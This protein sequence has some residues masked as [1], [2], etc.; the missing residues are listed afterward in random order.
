MKTLVVNQEKCTACRRCELTCSFHKTGEFN[1]ASSRVTVAIF[2][3]VDFYMPITCQQ[4]EDALCQ[5]ACPAAA[6]SRSETTGAVVI[7]ENRCIGCQMCVMVCPFGAVAFSAAE[8]KV[9]KCDLCGGDPECAKFCAWG[10]IEYREADRITLDKRKQVG[11]KLRDLM[12]EVS[13]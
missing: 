7:D 4:C 6:I 1:P 10:A 8:S 11:A 12:K 9:V 2:P 5:K 3:E 13:A